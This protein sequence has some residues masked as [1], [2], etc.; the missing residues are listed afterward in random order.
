M[1]SKLCQINDN[2][3]SSCGKV[4][5]WRTQSTRISASQRFASQ[6]RWSHLLQTADFGRPK[7]FSERP[8]PKKFG[9]GTLKPAADKPGFAGEGRAQQV[10]FRKGPDLRIMFGPCFFLVPY[11]NGHDGI[12]QPGPGVLSDVAVKRCNGNFLAP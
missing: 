11:P 8:A 2:V 9:F 7:E 5:S 3:V 12:E 4:I 10:W 6:S 1:M